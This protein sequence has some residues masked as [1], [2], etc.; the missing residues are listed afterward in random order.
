MISPELQ[1]LEFGLLKE[2]NI[3]SGSLTNPKNDGRSFDEKGNEYENEETS[4]NNMENSVEVNFD[5][6]WQFIHSFIQTIYGA[7]LYE[8]LLFE[9]ENELHMSKYST[10][11]ACSIREIV[12]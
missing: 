7:E 10:M 3:S 8:C 12:D 1:K 2:L 6:T 4:W 11:I 9:V 5:Q